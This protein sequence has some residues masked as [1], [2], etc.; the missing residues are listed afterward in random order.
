VFELIHPANRI[1]VDYGEEAKLVYLASFDPAGNEFWHR[2]RVGDYGIDIVKFSEFDD[3][4]GAVNCK[5]TKNREGFVVRWQD[6]TREKVKFDEYK[7]LH[8]VVFGTTEWTVWD[9]L[10]HGQNPPTGVSPELDVW[11]DKTKARMFKDWM[12]LSYGILERYSIYISTH[13]QT[14]KEFALLV[15]GDRNES[16]MFLLYDGKMEEHEAY[17]WKQL[18]PKKDT[19]FRKE[20]QYV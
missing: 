13:P 8:R 11:I 4:L 10:R 17:L 5:E 20:S 7:R 14:R 9:C 16:A 18:E 1:V 19:L 2:E 12:L 15:K 3:V 6:G